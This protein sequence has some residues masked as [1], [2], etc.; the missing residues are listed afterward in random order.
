MRGD[1]VVE[2]GAGAATGL[3]P[4]ARYRWASLRYAVV[5]L[6]PAVAAVSLFLGGLWTFATPFIFLGLVPL[7]GLLLQGSDANPSPEEE[8][9]LARC[10]VFDAVLYAAVP[11][12]WGLI[13]LTAWVV[14][15]G[16]L[17]GWEY[18]GVILSVGLSCGVLGVNVAH[19]LGHR[20]GRLDQGLAKSLLLTTLFMHFIIAHNRG[21][22]AEVGTRD[23]PATARRWETVYTFVVRSAVLSWVEAWSLENERFRRQGRSPWSLDNEMIRFQALQV[24]YIVA[25]MLIFGLPAALVLVG[26]AAM[27]VVLLENINYIAHYGLARRPVEGGYGPILAVHSWNSNNPM[28]RYILF[29]L[30]RHSDHHTNARRRYQALRSLDVSPQLPSGYPTM[31]ML[32]WLP[33]LWFRVMHRHMEAERQRLL[34]TGAYTASDLEPL[35][36]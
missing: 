9:E 16:R 4:A 7:A 22:H 34:A 6:I 10:R 30:S 18:L 14:S 2:E 19:E 36:F 1:T 28:S 12:Q 33:P 31:M 25:F 8:R 21:H 15:T 13:V 32:A 35:H 24:L 23:D 11:I 17:V 29:E 27:G 3:V 26:A 5:Y 20:R